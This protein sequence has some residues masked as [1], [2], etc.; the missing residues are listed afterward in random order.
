MTAGV[1]YA[2][3]TPSA[4]VAEIAFHRLLFFAE[5][6]DIPW[7]ANP[8]EYTAFCA[9]YA[10]RKAIDLTRG[11]YDRHKARWMH[12]ADYRHCQALADTARAV[13][14]EIIRY[15]SVRHP[16]HGINVA[17]LTCRA[18]ASAKPIKQQT[19]HIRLSDAGVQAICEAPRS[20]ITFDCQAFADDP[21]IAEL[22]WARG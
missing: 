7:P 11:K 15:R 13:K 10:T 19:W 16:G 3:E 1:F 8:A 6:P 21:R 5:S 12:V 18:F 4:A 22:R 2:S 17:L 14:V 20:G 9:K